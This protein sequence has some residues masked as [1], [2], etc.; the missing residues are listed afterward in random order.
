MKSIFSASL[1]FLLVCFQIFAQENNLKPRIIN[2]TDLGADPDDQQSMVR[3]LV[4]SNEFDVEG[5]IVAT[6]CWRTTQNSTSMLDK[7]V[8]AYEQVYDNL[9]VHADGYPTPEYL[10]SISVLGQIE[11]GMG[12][13]G[14]SKDSPGSELI[15]EAVDKEDPRPVW[16]TG[17]GG[18]NNV[19]QAI[20]KVQNER[21]SEELAEFIS[22]LRVFDI[23]G[24]DDGGAWLTKNFPDLFYIRATGVYGWAPSD[25]WIDI[26][27]HNHG[28]L[29]AEYPDRKY[30]TEGDTPSFMHVYLNGL[31]DPEKID[32]GGWGG[33]F[34]YSKVANLR[35]MSK[36]NEI[37]DESKYDPYY[38][39]TNTSEGSAAI[40]RWQSGYDNDFEAR[41]DWSIKSEYS[42]AN[43]HPIAIVNGDSTK[44]VLE[45]SASPGSTV[46]L[47]AFGSFDP[48]GD[49][50]SYKW[51]WYKEA[52][53]YFGRSVSIENSN[54]DAP[55][56]QVPTDAVDKDIHII[57]ELNDSGSPSLYAY[58]RVL[59]KVNANNSQ[60]RWVGTWSTA[61]YAAGTN[62]PPSPYLANNTLRQ[63][64]RTSIAGDTLRVKFSNI[65][66]P[67]PVTINSVN[68]AASSGTSVIDTTTIKELKFNGS[69]SVTMNAYSEVTSD[70]IDYSLA[71][72]MY[73]AITI[74]YG[75]CE[76]SSNM[77]FHY[78]S[79][80]DSYILEG[81]QSKS[82]DFTGATIVERWYNLSSID[83]KSEPKSA[84]VA[85]IGNS[86]TDAYGV[87]NG[88]GNKWT[89][90]FSE[91]LLDDIST[92]HVGVL[93]LGIGATTVIGS[94]LSRFQQ[95]ILE[96]AGLRWI[97]CFYG[98]NDIGANQSADN[99]INAYRSMISQAHNQNIRIYGAT[100]TPFNGHSYYSAAREAVRVEVNKWIRTS[101]N[102]DKCIDFDKA[103]RDP[104]DTT[105]LY[106][107]YSNDWLHPNAAGYQ[108]LGE[109]VDLNL[110]LGAD[111]LYEQS[112]TS[113]IESHYFEP[114]CA[115]VGENWD[116]LED[117]QASN[118]KY[119]TVKSGIQSLTEPQSGGEAL[120]TI[121]FISDTTG[122]YSVFA[123]LN[124]PTYD[125]DSFWVKMDNGEFVMNNGLVTSGWQW[126]KF[127]DYTLTEGDHILTIA[128]REDGAKLDKICLT[129]SL[130]PP[131]GMGDDAE[132]LCNPTDIGMLIEVIDD[133]S[134]GQNYPNPFNPITN[135]DYTIPKQTYVSL[136]VYDLLGE[137]VATLF[138]G[139]NREGKY[140]VTFDGNS[141]ASGI[142]FYRLMTDNFIE[143]KKLVFLK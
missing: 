47:N 127:G 136:K 38:M 25:A 58:R 39:Y 43:H 70:P 102:F 26:N 130:Y 121:P 24:Q 59:I 33:R 10:K 100:I 50:L 126:I 132:N 115:T 54:T 122:S 74:Y 6:G 65:T 41:M 16:V 91:K 134:L 96:Q 109:S 87:H 55:T 2:T 108:L 77:T 40:S 18:I 60:S 107:T 81:D 111:T 3:F 72:G 30:A 42:E 17:W 76:T 64:I 52:S 106:A 20:W 35:G 79:R 93:N 53:S 113:G 133:Y 31:N 142:Y 78:G 69:Q 114:E 88:P 90:Y 98:V 34:S 12:A 123:R 119:V 62:T 23:L 138:E 112:D 67:T 89:D 45:I 83:V 21:T 66:S 101:G 139:I 120:I 36:V 129:N 75:Q 104:S 68:F 46:Y 37:S 84:S 7:I 124:C 128:Y 11:Y 95:D 103:I 44:Q 86:I 57:L 9:T 15:I 141:F 4:C 29:G 22:K 105:K 27:I 99:I 110:F 80:T 8:N 97:I 116:I 51:S 5:L 28:V 92:S 117:I 48:D 32:Q 125:D 135:I 49:S 19:A 82:A 94:G 56:I 85:V 13:V 73:L 63:I 14:D 131:L 118:G 143:T 137:E 1:I 71:P 140:T 61:P